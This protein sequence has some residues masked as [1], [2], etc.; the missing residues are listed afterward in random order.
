MKER[1]VFSVA[2]SD[3][4][5]S[6]VSIPPK[7]IIDLTQDVNGLSLLAINCG[8]AITWLQERRL[9]ANGDKHG[10]KAKLITTKI[11]CNRLINDIDRQLSNMI[12]NKEV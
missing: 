7:D 2:S 11:A 5:A 12:A 4:P 3:I 9:F 6:S 10:L 1:N 8:A